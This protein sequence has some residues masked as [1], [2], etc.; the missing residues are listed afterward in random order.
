VTDVILYPAID[1]LDGQ[2][3]RLVRGDFDEST[4][5]R[6]SPLEAA[7]SWVEAGARFL[8][9]VDLDGA[10]TGTPAHLDQLAA[11]TEELDV[12]VQWGGG[13]RDIDSVKAALAA[14]A[15]RVILGTAAITDPDFLDSVLGSHR[16]RVMVSVDTRGGKVATK[17]WLET[18]EID[19][20]EAITRL[21]QRGVRRF[22]YTNADRDGLE[23][24]PDMDEVRRIS[25]AVR[26]SWIFSGGIGTAGHLRELA[27]ARLVNLGGVITG[28]ALYEKRFTIAEGHAALQD[29]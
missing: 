26:G 3:V 11:I 22:V 5:Y 25:Q 13:L 9:I 12:P 24:G 15:E 21:Q 16:D 1:I 6:D 27:Q 28:K 17:G 4:V 23:E 7:R 2:A 10:K 20:A 18:T 29:R 8:H 14:G 19:G